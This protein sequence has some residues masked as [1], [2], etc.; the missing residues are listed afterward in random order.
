[1]PSSTA[2]C[3]RRRMQSCRQNDPP[4]PP[5][6][7]HTQAAFS[8]CRCVLTWAPAARGAHMWCSLQAAA[9]GVCMQVRETKCLCLAVVM[10]HGEGRMEPPACLPV[11]PAHPPVLLVCA[12]SASLPTS[13]TRVP[14]MYHRMYC[15]GT[16]CC[17]QA[18]RPATRANVVCGPGVSRVRAG[19]GGC[20][21]APSGGAAKQV[22]PAQR[23]C[24]W[25]ASC[26][27]RRSARGVPQA[28]Q[29]T[30][31]AKGVVG[32]PE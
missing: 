4:P 14:S 27:Q 19:N 11:L 24:L 1:M 2:G 9:V 8:S 25:H 3:P 22:P 32:G 29:A 7:T 17:R 12:L 16:Q 18:G 31:Q 15:P 28:S 10:A 20:V 30:H 23:R 13:Y 5:P 6:N 21:W 26:W